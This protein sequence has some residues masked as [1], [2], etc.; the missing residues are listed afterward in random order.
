[1]RIL[2]MLLKIGIV[3]AV[4]ILIIFV[5]VHYKEWFTRPTFSEKAKTRHL[6]VLSLDGLKADDFPKFKDLPNF[7]KILD[8][9]SYAKEVKGIYPSLTYPS[10]TT[11]VTGKY[12]INH[13]IIDNRQFQPGVKK[14]DWHWYSKDIKA[15]TLYDVANKYNMRVGAMLWPV[16]ANA[17]IDYN[18]PEIWSNKGENQV[19]LSL[20]SGSPLF[21]L[22]LQLRYGEMRNGV[23]Q[24]ELDDFTA[25]STGYMIR[26]KKPNLALIHFTDL[27][28]H[29]HIYG[30]NSKEADEAIKRHDKR[31]GDILKAIEEAG[32]SEDAT[33]VVLG[34]HGFLDVQNRI[35]VNV[36][37]KEAGLITEDESGGLKDWKAYAQSSDGSAYVYLKDKNDQDTRKKVEKILNTLKSNPKNGIETVYTKAQAAKLKAN[38][39]CE[40]MLEGRQGYYFGNASAGKLVEKIEPSQIDYDKDIFAATHG[41]SPEKKEIKTFFMASGSGIK[42]GVALPSINLVDEGPTMAALLGFDLPGADGRILEEIIENE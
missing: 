22:S 5:A 19:L 27:D 36:A 7:K 6:I 39:Q 37:F 8:K 34:D 21:L 28:K 1:M 24:P 16:T 41:F 33:I 18:C 29:R 23:H 42:K 4:V 20:K 11:I 13:G 26:S 12:P 14:Q 40:F 10:H 3:L 25:A 30:V 2:K 17:K 31:L 32:I 38:D 9:G 15:R 35:N